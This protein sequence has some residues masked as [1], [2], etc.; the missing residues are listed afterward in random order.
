M[1][2][3]ELKSD[4]ANQALVEEFINDVEKLYKT[5]KTGEDGFAVEFMVSLIFSSCISVVDLLIVS[6]C[7]CLCFDFNQIQIFSLWKYH[8]ITIWY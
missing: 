5:T 3:V 7:G 1:K 6:I 2:R 4:M 8:T